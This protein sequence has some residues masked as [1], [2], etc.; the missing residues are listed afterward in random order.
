MSEG[1]KPIIRQGKQAEVQ[2]I[3]KQG[4]QSIEGVTTYWGSITRSVS[5]KEVREIALAAENLTQTIPLANG[6]ERTYYNPAIHRIIGE[7]LKEMPK[8]GHMSA[9]IDE[10]ILLS[11]RFMDLKSAE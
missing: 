11:E 8:Y 2:E 3:T 10:K 1:Y 6:T 7:R 4:W 9:Q 5:S